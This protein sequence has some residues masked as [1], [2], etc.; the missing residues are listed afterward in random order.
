M[1]FVGLSLATL[2]TSRVQFWPPPS[3]GSWQHKTIR[4]LFRVFI[5][6]LVALSVMTFNTDTA[7]ALQYAIG[8]PLLVVGFGL[9]VY[10]TCFL[11][12]RNAFGEATG[13][14]TDGAYR[15]SRNPIYVVSIVGMIGWCVVVSNVWV[16]SLLV[17][18]GLFYGLAPFLEE[19]WL[20]RQYGDAFRP[21]QSH[22]PRFFNPYNYRLS[23]HRQF[24][25]GAV[26]YRR[27]VERS[28]TLSKGLVLASFA[29][30]HF[31]AFK[32]FV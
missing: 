20:E 3:A 17:L 26:H 29:R 28:P 32:T 11:G 8:M 4:G 23:Q 7:F 6:G 22:V 9:A 27:V 14:K 16:A 10:W 21:Y 25:P 1:A 13:L 15:W 31:G 12:W 5:V 30:K 2:V 19:P 24:V 18:W